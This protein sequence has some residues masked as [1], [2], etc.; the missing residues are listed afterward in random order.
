MISKRLRAETNVA[1]EAYHGEDSDPSERVTQQD[2]QRSGL[3]QCSPD[4]QEQTSSD[5]AAE[6][7]ELDVTGFQP[8]RRKLAE[9]L[10]D[11]IP[12]RRGGRWCANIPTT[13]VSIVLGSLDVPIHIRGFSHPHAFMLDDLGW[14]IVCRRPHGVL[15]FLHLD[16]LHQSQVCNSGVEALMMMDRRQS[17]QQGREET[18][19]KSLE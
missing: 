17:Q 2:T 13:D 15:L 3:R 16:G 9:S 14:I 18:R 8:F 19:V 7:D 12:L 4:S 10:V 6:S 1:K 5:G 11:T